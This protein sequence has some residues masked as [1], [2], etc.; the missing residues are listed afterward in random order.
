[1][2]GKYMV[3]LFATP[4]RILVALVAVITLAGWFTH[5]EPD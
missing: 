2:F 4:E 1:M 5:K 3:E